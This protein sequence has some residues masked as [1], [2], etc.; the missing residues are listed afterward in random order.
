MP[1]MTRR[2]ATRA[3]AAAAMLGTF[4]IL[5]ERARGAEFVYKF[6]ND[7]PATHPMNIRAQEAAQRILEESGGQL[8]L[9]VFPNNQLGGDTDM[10]A[11]LRSG[12]LE[13]LSLSGNIL[14]SVVKVSSLYGI[15]FAFTGYDPIWAALD[16][17]MGTFLRGAIAKSNMHALDKIWDNGFRQIT[18]STHPINGPDDLRNF[19]IRVPVSPLWTFR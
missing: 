12:A 18:S 9:R 13:T 14:S 10:L 5:S 15:A 4:G 3:G 1:T 17:E 7:V 19:K 16:G 8:E 11:Q 2:G 6:G